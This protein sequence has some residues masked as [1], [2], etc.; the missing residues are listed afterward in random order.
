MPREPDGP[1]EEDDARFKGNAPTST[2]M[3]PGCGADL[4]THGTTIVAAPL[5]R[6]FS[7]KDDQGRELLALLGTRS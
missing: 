2:V 7:P 6:C 3:C 5:C 4:V 1:E